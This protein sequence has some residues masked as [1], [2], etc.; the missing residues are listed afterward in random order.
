MLRT[1][2]RNIATLVGAM[3]LWFIL[4]TIIHR[5]ACAMWPAYAAATPSLT[6]TLPMMIFRL[7][8]STVCTLAVGAVL[9]RIGAANWMPVAFGCA[10][11]LLF[12]PEHYRIWSRLPV[13]YHLTFLLSLIPLAVLGARMAGGRPV[14]ATAS[15][16]GGR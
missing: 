2:L 10:L 9:R 12:A 11:I 1:V 13:W 5:I 3:V 15:H 4:A 14:L 6:F 7:G 8:L 16:A